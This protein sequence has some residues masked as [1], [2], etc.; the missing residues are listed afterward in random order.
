MP[1]NQFLKYLDNTPRPFAD[2]REKQDI[3][4]SFDEKFQLS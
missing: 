2:L 1:H 3:C 4:L